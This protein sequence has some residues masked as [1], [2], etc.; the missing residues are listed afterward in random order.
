M[1]LGALAKVVYNNR[2]KKYYKDMKIT[3][4]HKVIL[5]ELLQT[6]LKTNDL[7]SLII[8]SYYRTKDQ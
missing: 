6:L 4:Y 8:R 7:H 3:L 5:I 2:E 1:G